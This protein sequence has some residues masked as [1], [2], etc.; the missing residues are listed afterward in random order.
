MQHFWRHRRRIGG[1]CG[2]NGVFLSARLGA[3][4]VIL[5]LNQA[6]A[7]WTYSQK[8]KA[9]SLLWYTKYGMQNLTCQPSCRIFC[10]PHKRTGTDAC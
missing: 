2:G 10:A 7:M 4:E 6:A 8:R 3:E 9:G 5:S 1:C